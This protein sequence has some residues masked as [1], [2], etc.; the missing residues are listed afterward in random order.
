[1]SLRP[2]IT[3]KERNKKIRIKYA[4]LSY[5]LFFT[6]I[7][8]AFG[9][10]DLSFYTTIEIIR[11]KKTNYYQKKRWVMEN[12]LSLDQ[13]ENGSSLFNGKGKKSGNIFFKQREKEKKE[14]D[15][16]LKKWKEALQ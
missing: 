8:S 3:R 5:F 9:Q 4:P 13:N 11:D 1:M 12:I 7:S 2:F 6:L 10:N 14:R 15:L 16:E